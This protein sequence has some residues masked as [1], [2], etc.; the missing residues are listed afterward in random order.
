MN[1]VFI[2]TEAGV[3]HNGSLIIAKRLIDKAAEAGADAIKFQTFRAEGFIAKYAPKAAYQKL[4]SDKDETQ[5]EMIKNLELDIDDYKRLQT[6]CYKKG[7]IFL[8]SPFDLESIDMVNELNLPIIK[9]PSSEITNLPYLRKVGGLNKEI[10]LSTGMSRLCEIRD[11]LEVLIR[12][13]MSKEKIT[14]LQCNT[15]YPTPV[16][17]VNLLA[18][19][20]IAKEFKVKSGYSDHTLGIEVPIAAVAIGAS[21]IEKH[22]TINRNMPGPDHKA[23]LEPAEL[24][25]MINMIRNVEKAMGDGIKMPTKSELKNIGVVRKSIVA[26]R[27]IKKG[28]RFSESNIAVKRPGLGISPMKWDKIIGLRAK[29]DFEKDRN[30]EI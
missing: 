14:V 13:G 10:I 18:M 29:K 9:I 4:N 2:I 3:N 7:I 1:K 17:D 15:A 19:L 8:S 6:H 27:T 21:V 24:K 11:A 20:T 23:S 12:A 25:L 30:I 16:V 26:A 5:F 22:F 28:E